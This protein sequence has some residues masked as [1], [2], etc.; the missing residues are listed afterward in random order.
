MW[1]RFFDKPIGYGFT[2]READSLWLLALLNAFN[3]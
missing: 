2:L 3:G 1:E